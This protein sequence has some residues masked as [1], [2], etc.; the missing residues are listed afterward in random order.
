MALRWKTVEPRVGRVVAIAPYAELSNVVL[1]ICHEYAGCLPRTWVKA[2]LKHLPSLLMVEP[3]QLDTTQVLAR[4]PVIA[5]FAAG[6]EDRIT[7]LT[8]VR[9]LH[10]GAAP[11]SELV[12]VPGATHEA[13]TYFFEELLPPVLSWLKTQ[14]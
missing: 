11:G 1:N 7:P 6:T 4:G 13:V 12:V 14:N 3:G 5:L 8:D 2:G 9:K 10:Q